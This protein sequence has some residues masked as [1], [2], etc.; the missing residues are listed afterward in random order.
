MFSYHTVLLPSISENMIKGK[1]NIK[2]QLVAR[3]DHP[4]IMEPRTIQS[5]NPQNDIQNSSSPVAGH[6]QPTIQPECGPLK[7]KLVEILEVRGGEEIMEPSGPCKKSAH[8]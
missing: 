1:L 2:L 6:E 8:W 5:T 3:M 4:R 7:T